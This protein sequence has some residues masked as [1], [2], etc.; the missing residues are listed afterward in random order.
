MASMCDF[1]LGVEKRRFIAGSV[2]ESNKGVGGQFKNMGQHV[3]GLL[4]VSCVVTGFIKER[5]LV[6]ITG[7]AV[8]VV[9]KGLRWVSSASILYIGG[10]NVHCQACVVS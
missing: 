2:D 10:S 8:F 5:L 7:E 6:G 4:N 9:F 1:V 3:L